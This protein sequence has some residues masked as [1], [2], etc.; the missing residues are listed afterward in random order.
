MRWSIESRVPFLENDFAQFLL[1]LPENYL[2]SNE[3]LS[4]NIFRRSMEGIVPKEVLYRRDKIG[5]ET[6]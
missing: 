4:K 1:S 2:V 5:F 6:P 3:G